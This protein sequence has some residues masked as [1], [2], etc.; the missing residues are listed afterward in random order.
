MKNKS[1]KNLIIFISLVAVIMVLFVIIGHNKQESEE[2]TT[3]LDT[4]PVVTVPKTTINPEDYKDKIPYVGMP[5][6]AINYTKLGEADRPH[7]YLHGHIEE[8]DHVYESYIWHP[9]TC[10]DIIMSAKCEYGKVIE[11]EK[12]FDD[13]Y[14]KGDEPLLDAKRNVDCD[15]DDYD[16]D[17]DD[18]EFDPDDYDSGEDYADDAYGADFDDWDEA[19]DYWEDNH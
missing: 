6:S 1:Y 7:N 16:V 19:Y 5:E 18:L 14:W 9:H 4:R 15:D 8:G 10:N 2:P 13:T 12:W 3:V 11:V 17:E